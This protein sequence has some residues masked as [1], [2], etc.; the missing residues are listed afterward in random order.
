MSKYIEVEKALEP[1]KDLE[2]SDII[3]I[4]LFKENLKQQPA[5]EVVSREYF[6][7]TIELYINLLGKALT[8]IY[9]LLEIIRKE[10]GEI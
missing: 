6:D 8:T 7:S 10:H 1:Y 3:S 9:K 4:W 5:A 2:D